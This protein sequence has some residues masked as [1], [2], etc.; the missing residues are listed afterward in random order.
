ME[1]AASQIQ[2]LIDERRALFNEEVPLP[3]FLNLGNLEARKVVSLGVSGPVAGAAWRGETLT[4]KISGLVFCIIFFAVPFS[5]WRYGWLSGFANIMLFYVHHRIQVALSSRWFRG[6][7]LERPAVFHLFY[8][9]G[10]LVIKHSATSR[11]VKSPE[12]WMSFVQMLS[13]S[14][15]D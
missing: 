1:E 3:V 8:C 2:K 15:L 14:K 6:Y 7:V 4:G 9:Q 13:Q 11:T 5:F 10:Q 12:N